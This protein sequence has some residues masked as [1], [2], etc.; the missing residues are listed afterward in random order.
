MD[1]AKH[2]AGLDFFENYS[3]EM[4]KVCHKSVESVW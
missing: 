3:R 1:V 2:L 4:S